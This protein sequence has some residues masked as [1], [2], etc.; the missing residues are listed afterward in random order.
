MTLLL[1]ESLC[2]GCIQLTFKT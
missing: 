1:I 2:N